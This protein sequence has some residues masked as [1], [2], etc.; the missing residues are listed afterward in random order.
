MCSLRRIIEANGELMFP[1]VKIFV[2]CRSHGIL[3]SIIMSLFDIE[4]SSLRRS[5]FS[6]VSS[7]KTPD[8]GFL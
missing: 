4:Q 3:R 8:R 2:L 5:Y 7:L 1:L 6:F